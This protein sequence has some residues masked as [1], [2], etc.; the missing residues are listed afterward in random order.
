MRDLVDVLLTVLLVGA[1]AFFVGAEFSLISVRRDRLEAL[2]EQG[3]ASA[4]TVIRA[5][6]RLPLMFAGAQFG[7]TV[8]SILLGRIGEPAVADLLHTPLALLHVSG[9]LLHTVSFVVALA[10]VVTLHVLLARWCPRTSRSPAGEGRDVAGSAVSGLRAGGAP[11]D[12]VL[13]LECHRDPAAA[14]CAAERRAR[15]HSVHG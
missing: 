15:R 11:A 10:V 6:E 4:A 1:N 2:A 9:A 8:S 3:R 5:G 13:Q 12:R 7:I 14:A